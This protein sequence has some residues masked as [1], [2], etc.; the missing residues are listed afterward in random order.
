MNNNKKQKSLVRHDGTGLFWQF[1]K[2]CLEITEESKY[3]LKTQILKDFL[4][5]FT[6]DIYLLFKLLLPKQDKRVFRLQDKA[7]VQVMSQVLGA[8]HDDMLEHL[9]KG[10][11]SETCKKFLIS[12]GMACKRGSVSLKQVDDFLDQLTT[13]TKRDEQAQI[14]EK[15]IPKLT[16][17]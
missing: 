15:F 6:G 5:S 17:D 14:F 4:E 8:D 3:T 12:C 10:D 7:L 16:G 1:V 2:L 9:D 13:V 11:A